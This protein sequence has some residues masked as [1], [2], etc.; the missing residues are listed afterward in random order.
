MDVKDIEK[1][2]LENIAI[3][4][5]IKNIKGK[6]A[7]RKKISS[8]LVALALAEKTSLEFKDATLKVTDG[9]DDYGIDGF[10]LD[11]VKKT[12]W[13]IQ[14]KSS[15]SGEKG[16]EKGEIHKFIEGIEKILKKDFNNFNQN[17]KNRKEEINS[18]LDSTDIMFKMLYINLGSEITKKTGEPIKSFL[19]KQ[20]AQCDEDWIDFESLNKKDIIEIITKCNLSKNIELEILLF[21]WGV[22]ENPFTSYYGTITASIIGEWFKKYGT[23]L[24]SKNIRDF[25]GRGDVNSKIINTL[26]TVPQNFYYLNNGIT[27]ICDEV[28]K[29]RA[30][31]RETTAGNFK[32][33]GVQIINGAQTVGSIGHVYKKK[34]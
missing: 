29:T 22:N 7:K 24:F 25:L 10:H 15:E 31:G 11:I 19:E 6:G 28:K 23:F 8:S 13:I 4:P 2:L 34:F 5:D 9:Y 30:S 12:F 18:A 3:Y 32:C 26:E 27:I 16:V 14:A 33:K 20:N 21:H 17:I 1:F